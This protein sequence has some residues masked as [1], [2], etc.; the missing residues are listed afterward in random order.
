LLSTKIKI[1]IYRPI[2][3]HVVFMGVKLGLTLRMFKNRALRKISDPK[4]DKV[5]GE[6]KGVSNK[7]I[8]DLYSSLNVKWVIKSG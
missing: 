8:C 5:T 4:R 6:W 7:E 3:L 1:K 2:I